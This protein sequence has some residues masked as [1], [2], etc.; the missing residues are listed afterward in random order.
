MR[1]AS[2]KRSTA[3]AES[4]STAVA[5]TIAGC[6]N[7]MRAARGTTTAATTTTTASMARRSFLIGCLSVGVDVPHVGRDR[8]R[9][10]VSL[11]APGYPCSSFIFRTV[12]R[13]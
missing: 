7:S 10:A 2:W 4:T 6:R 11:Q 9:D 12:E 5:S 13:T 1:M 8:G 3:P